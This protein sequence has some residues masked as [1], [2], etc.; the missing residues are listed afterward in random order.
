V[1]LSGS[2]TGINVPEPEFGF[3]F[4]NSPQWERG[5]HFFIYWCLT[6]EMQSGVGPSN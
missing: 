6:A 5:F 3:I 4:S 2:C 1:A